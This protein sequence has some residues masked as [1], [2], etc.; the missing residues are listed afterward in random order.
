MY[1][2]ARPLAEAVRQPRK[3]CARPA[4]PAFRA[5]CIAA[6]KTVGVFAALIVLSMLAAHGGPIALA[7]GVLFGALFIALVVR[8]VNRRDDPR[9]ARLPPD[10]P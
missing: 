4:G 1:H 3:R 6:A 7:V 9:R 8:S 5:S 2:E 10:A